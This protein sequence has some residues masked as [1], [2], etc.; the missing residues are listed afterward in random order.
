MQI[1]SKQVTY[2]YRSVS[3]QVEAIVEPP[4]RGAGAANAVVVAHRI[5]VKARI[6]VFCG[7]HRNVCCCKQ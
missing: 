7:A 1:Y 2:E 5:A 3:W 4:L 6:I